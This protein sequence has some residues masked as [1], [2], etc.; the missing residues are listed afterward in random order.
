MAK[1]LNLDNAD[2]EQMRAVQKALIDAALPFRERTEAAL[3]VFACVRIARTM[4]RLY[5]PKTQKQLLPVII[6]FLEGKTTA[7][8]VESDFLHLQ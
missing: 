3:V 7:P 4:L 1:N 5:N 6:A 2:A 8:G